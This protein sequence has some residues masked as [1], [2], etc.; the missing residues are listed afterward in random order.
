MSGK[1]RAIDNGPRSRPAVVRRREF[2]QAA[3]ATVGGFVLPHLLASTARASL[4]PEVMRDK[5][6][7][8]LFLQGG[9]SHIEFFD[10]KMNAPTE[11]RSKTGEVKTKHPGIT[12]GGTFPKL[13]AMADKFSIV[14]SYGTQ[15][16]MHTYLSITGGGN[17]LKASAG[18]IC[19]QLGGTAHPTTGVPRHCLILPEAVQDGLKLE[20]NFETDRIPSLHDPGTLGPNF[21][22]FD[23]SNGEELQQDLTLSLS[24]SRFDER[25]TLLKQLDRLGGITEGV[26]GRF[27]TQSENHRLAFEAITGNVAQV[28]DLSKEDPRTLA[29]YDT[30]KLF[31]NTEVQQWEDMRRATNLLG[32]QLLLARRLCERGCGY[33]TVSDCGWDMHSDGATPDDMGAMWPKGRQVDHAVSAFLEDVYQRGL[34]D[35]ILLVV[36][37]EMGRTPRLNEKGGRDHFGEL[38]PLLIAGGGLEMGKVIG[39]TDRNAERATTE[40]FTPSN[41]FS[42]IMHT[43]FDVTQLRLVPS[44]PSELLRF[45]ETNKPITGLGL[46]S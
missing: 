5:S 7:V 41:L 39:E 11:F 31:P 21:K 14:R 3:A 29:R 40:P 34:Q 42:T 19:A 45:I 9:P 8:F 35:R 46:E 16:T 15:N 44:V 38:T 12:F 13:A 22:A 2:L 36:S 37:G 24:R 20:I 10:P 26:E 17:P 28:F 4:P 1:I 30:S 18:A 6:V 32:R 27:A 33:V 25:R 43:L 23:P